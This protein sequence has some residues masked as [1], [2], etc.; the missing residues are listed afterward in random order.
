[1]QANWD[2]ITTINSELRCQYNIRAIWDDITTNQQV[3]MSLQQTTA[4]W[5]VITTASWN[6]A[7][8]LGAPDD[9]SPDAAPLALVLLHFRHHRPHRPLP[10]DLRPPVLLLVLH[11][12]VAPQLGLLPRRL[13]LL[14][15]RVLLHL[16]SEK[17]CFD[18]VKILRSKHVIYDLFITI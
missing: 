17:I 4:S 13:R 9:R 7:L 8:K 18:V 5:D 10:P 14:V 11:P 15:P 1:M 16:I 2:V 6:V 12:R 3:E